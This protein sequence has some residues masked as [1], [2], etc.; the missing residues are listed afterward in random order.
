MHGYFEKPEETAA[1]LDD[2]GWLDT[3]DLGYLTED[4]LYITGRVRDLIIING[5]NI[6]PQDLEQIAE[7]QTAVRIGDAS[8]FAVSHP[9]TGDRAVV[10]VQCRLR[11]AGERKSLVS[12]IRVAVYEHFGLQCVVDLVPPGTL[13][14]TSSGKLARGEAKQDFLRRSES[15]QLEAVVGATH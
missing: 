6:W 14:R 1:T 11:D 9:G 7:Q 15:G 3:G 5:R 2:E 4:G 12:A 13:P 10:V 8:A